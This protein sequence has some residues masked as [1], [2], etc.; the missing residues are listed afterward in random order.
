MT[1]MKM[2]ASFA[3]L[4]LLTLAAGA[5]AGIEPVSATASAPAPD[6]PKT[7]GV[8]GADV[9]RGLQSLTP[10]QLDQVL[11]RYDKFDADTKR[12]FKD[13]LAH[14]NPFIIS[15]LTTAADRI[16]PES[17]QQL[18]AEIARVKAGK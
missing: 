6:A 12:Q 4:V 10:A 5:A 14:P 3:G 16:A 15:L 2:K 1:L 17:R 13:A 18:A 9:V 7:A 11:A 8:S